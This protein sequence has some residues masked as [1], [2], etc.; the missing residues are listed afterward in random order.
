MPQHGLVRPLAL[1]VQEICRDECEAVNIVPPGVSEHEWSPTPKDMIAF[2]PAVAG[3]GIGLD[4]DERFFK[5]VFSKSKKPAVPVLFFGPLVRPRKWSQASS[6]T[7]KGD[8]NSAHAHHDGTRDHGDWD[9][10]V[11]FDPM[12]MSEA[13]PLIAESLAKA[14]PL[15]VDRLR[16]QAADIQVRLKAVDQEILKMRGSWGDATVIVFHDSLGYWADRYN[17]PVRALVSGGHG[18]E[19]SAKT[20]GNIAKEYREKAVAAVAVERLDGAS[21]NLARELKTKITVIDFPSGP[22]KG[23]YEQ[24][25]K[26]LANS[27]NGI[28]SVQSKH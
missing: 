9:P 15:S 12:R 18:H 6:Y 1:L 11:W 21:K 13:T 5:A 8:F 23:S 17:L 2:M 7:P 20:F 19:L 27:W 14:L 25:L 4:F 22:L 24:W 16:R 26:A 3:I 10:H 28:Y